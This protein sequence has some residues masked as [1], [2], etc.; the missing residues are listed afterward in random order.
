VTVPAGHKLGSC[1]VDLIGNTPGTLFHAGPVQQ[2]L[3]SQFW[4][5]V[6]SFWEKY[7]N[8]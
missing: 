3:R 8:K 1:V 2:Y 4:D 6:L 7:N 5:E